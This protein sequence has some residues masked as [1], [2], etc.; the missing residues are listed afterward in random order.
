MGTFNRNVKRII[1]LCGLLLLFTC[2]KNVDSGAPAPG[3]QEFHY[4]DSVFYI[5]GDNNQ[6]VKPVNSLQGTYTGF[7]LGLDI[8]TVTGEINLATSETG[9]KYLVSFVPDNSTDTLNT[10]V[11]IAGI[12]YADGFYNLN[13]DD[14]IVSPLYNTLATNSLPG[15]GGD[16]KFDIGGGCNSNGCNVI[17]GNGSINLAQTVRNGV[18]GEK[19][20]NGRSEEFE[21]EYKVDDKSGKSKDKIKIKLF[22]FKSKAD[23]TKEALDI[24]ASRQGTFLTASSNAVPAAAVRQKAGKPRPSCIF[25]VGR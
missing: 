15:V 16:T 25:I 17:P 11:T 22:Y 9:L 21:L 6:R 13:T 24:I 14:S 23:V 3:S 12:N 10:F 1:G 18:F 2:N 4:S 5:N 20:E 19:P 7:P 8:N